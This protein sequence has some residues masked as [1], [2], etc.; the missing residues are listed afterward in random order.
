MKI[1]F[2]FQNDKMLASFLNESIAIKYKDEAKQEYKE[3]IMFK[4]L[5]NSFRVETISINDFAGDKE[6]G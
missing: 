5:G 2:V 4:E 1:Y 6:N 3:S